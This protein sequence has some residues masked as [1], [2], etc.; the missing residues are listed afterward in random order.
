[1]EGTAEGDV[2][3]LGQRYQS[4][5]SDRARLVTRLSAALG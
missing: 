4:G 5:E 1:M 3:P 2:Q